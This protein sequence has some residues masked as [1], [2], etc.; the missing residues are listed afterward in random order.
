MGYVD[1]SPLVQYFKLLN[2]VVLV[3][4]LTW[5]QRAEWKGSGTTAE[6]RG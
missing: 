4:L 2:L 3:L 5:V 1:F 6:S